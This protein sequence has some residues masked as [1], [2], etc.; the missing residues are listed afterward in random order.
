MNRQHG[1]AASVEGVLE[2]LLPRESA[3]GI[4]SSLVTL[5]SEALTPYHKL[6]KSM[7]PIAQ[8]WLDL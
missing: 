5:N 2:G 7:R 4:M 8:P 6:G 3:L 1:C